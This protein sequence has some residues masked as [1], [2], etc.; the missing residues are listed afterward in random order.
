MIQ[1]AGSFPFAA[2][3]QPLVPY[4]TTA[5]ENADPF[6]T[7]STQSSQSGTSWPSGGSSPT[8]GAGFAQELW[9]YASGEIESAITRNGTPGTDSSGWRAFAF[10]CIRHFTAAHMAVA[11][12]NVGGTWMRLGL[13]AANGDRIAQTARFAP[14]ANTILAVPLLAPVNLLGSGGYYMG[15]WTDDTTGNLQFECLTGRSTSNR[16]PLMQRN[17]PNEGAGNLGTAFALTSLRPWL[18]VTE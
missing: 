8:P 15:Y 3:D 4:P 10:V 1:A 7:S 11:I 13:F 5:A 2:S 14:A 16:S 9:N 18:M 12:R 17:D 6:A